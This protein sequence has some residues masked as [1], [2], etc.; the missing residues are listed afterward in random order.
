MKDSLQQLFEKY[1]RDELTQAEL[2]RLRDLVQAGD[3]L[4]LEEAMQ[5]L[6]QDKPLPFSDRETNRE[7]V[8]RAISRRIDIEEALPPPVMTA[9]RGGLRRLWP[10][11]AVAAALLAGVLAGAWFFLNHHNDRPG[12]QVHDNIA[13]TRLLPPANATAWLTL[14]DGSRVPLNGAN[15]APLPAADSNA[16]WRKLQ[17]GGLLDYQDGHAAEDKVGYNTLTTSRGMQYQLILPDGSHVW[18]NSASAI[19]YPTAFAGDARTV[20]LAGEAYFEITPNA[21]APFHVKAHKMDVEVLG[22]G[23][24]IM[25]YADEPTLRTTLFQGSVKVSGAGAVLLRPGQQAVWAAGGTLNV[26]PAN[27]EEVAAWRNGKFLF[28][29]RSIDEIMRQISRWYDVE[30]EY[31]G[32]RPDAQFTGGLSR[33]AEASQLLEILQE[34]NN[35]HFQREGKKIIVTQ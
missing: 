17:R 27:L 20:E 15:G 14:A 18:L 16:R 29:R 34:T 1:L 28:R 10:R 33:T 5:G 22:T 35:V 13:A 8:F 12:R 24:N 19:R 25:S 32:P 7:R 11:Y 21:S 2:L 6:F 30:I 23:F 9:Q 31:R 26:Q 3:P 4:Q